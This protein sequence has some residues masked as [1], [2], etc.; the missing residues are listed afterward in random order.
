MIILVRG[1]YATEFAAYLYSCA[2][3]C[4]T[5]KHGITN[6]FYSVR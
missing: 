6:I 5:F 2:W 1:K 4:G 3:R